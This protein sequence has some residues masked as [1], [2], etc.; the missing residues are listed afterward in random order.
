MDYDIDVVIMEPEAGMKQSLKMLTKTEEEFKAADKILYR[1]YKDLPNANDWQTYVRGKIDVSLKNLRES[2]KEAEELLKLIS[3]GVDYSK[4]LSEY[5]DGSCITY[6][7][8]V[9]LSKQIINDT[10]IGDCTH[11]IYQVLC[12]DR[13]YELIL[14]LIKRREAFIF[15]DLFKMIDY[16]R[17]PWLRPIIREEFMMIFEPIVAAALKND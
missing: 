16:A 12:D 11:L 14:L 13:D 5:Y 1:Y 8:L 17:K 4:Q 3:N 2:I 10:L 9:T 6:N 15:D 7:R